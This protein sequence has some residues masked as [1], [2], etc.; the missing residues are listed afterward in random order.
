MK[1]HADQLLQIFSMGKRLRV[2]AIFHS[3]AEANAYMEKHPDE[4]VLASFDPYVFLANMH[5][6]GER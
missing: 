4:G 5:D 2:T 3:D 1:M 6:K